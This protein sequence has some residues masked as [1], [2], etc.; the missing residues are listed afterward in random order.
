MLRKKQPFSSSTLQ[1]QEIQT[2]ASEIGYT[3]EQKLMMVDQEYRINL[4]QK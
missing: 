3:L 1:S 2:N 4:M